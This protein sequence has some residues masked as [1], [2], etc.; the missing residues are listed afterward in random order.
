MRV[1]AMAVMS[2]I[3]STTVVFANENPDAKKLADSVIQVCNG[4][5][6]CLSEYSKRFEDL[7]ERLRMSIEHSK[8]V[9]EETK[10]ILEDP[11][12]NKSQGESRGTEK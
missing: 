11:V 8:A 5:A 9:L 1:V 3:M 4:D 10:W 7:A 6:E 2:L 12:T